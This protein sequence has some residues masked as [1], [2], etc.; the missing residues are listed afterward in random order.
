[1]FN[2]DVLYYKQ[3]LLKVSIFGKTNETVSRYHS[4]PN[5]DTRNT[6]GNGGSQ[7]KLF[8]AVGDSA[9]HVAGAEVAP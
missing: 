8:V 3:S 5:Y 2:P 6:T 9:D 1:M 7:R 4:H